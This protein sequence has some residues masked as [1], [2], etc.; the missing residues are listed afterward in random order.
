MTVLPDGLQL[1][2]R[3][4]ARPDPALA[5]LAVLLHSHLIGE[6]T[7][8]PGGDVEGWRQFL[9]LL[10]R[11]PQKVRADGGISRVWTATAHRHLTLREIDYAEVLKER[12]AGE[13]AVWDRATSG[14]ACRIPAASS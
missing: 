10:A 12:K 4:S 7:V 3:S 2:G 11:D 9:L 8:H 13:A 6:M 1:G 5:E 14:S